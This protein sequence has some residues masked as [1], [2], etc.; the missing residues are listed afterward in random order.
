MD[1]YKPES[2]TAR[3]SGRT[4]DVMPSEGDLSIAK[5][6]V[7]LA[8]D[9]ATVVHGEVK[10]VAE[11]DEKAPEARGGPLQIVGR[12][13]IALTTIMALAATASAYFDTRVGDNKPITCT[14]SVLRIG[15]VVAVG[16]GLG[17]GVLLLA[18]LV[19]KHPMY[20]SSPTE[21]SSA[22]HQEMIS[23]REPE[24]KDGKEK[25]K[26]TEESKGDGGSGKVAE[27]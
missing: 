21:F 11:K 5:Q 7:D 19:G 18:R 2:C 6:I 14:T 12:L 25:P 27:T 26:G 1:F 10:A 24:G 20:L 16:L 9:L 22:V 17:G 4:I 13:Y 15:V 3:T 23:A 8:K